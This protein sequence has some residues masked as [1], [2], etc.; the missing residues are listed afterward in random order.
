[1]SA[2]NPRRVPLPI[3]ALVP[4]LL[5]A[6]R[7]HP[8]AV[9]R[10]EPGAGKTTRV[11]PA[12]L[13]LV[14]PRQ[15]VLLLEPRRVVARAAA[16]R[17][18]WER[19][20]QVGEEVGYKVRFEDRTG[21]RTR[22]VVLTEGLL[23]R[24][25]QD[26]PTLD[27][28]GA[29][30]LDEL[31]ERSVHADLALAFLREVQEVRDDLKVV[32]MSAT[33][34][35]G[36]V[37]DFLGGVPVI[38]APGRTFPVT[39]SLL[40]RAD[41]R[42]PAELVV[43][44]V[45]RALRAEHGDEGG[46]VLAFL[47]GAA[48]IHRAQ[49]VLAPDLADRV[50]V[51]P[52]YG[53]LDP[54]A[55]DRAIEPGP[56]RKVVLSTNLAESSLTIEG[57][58]TVVDSGLEKQIRHD[59]SRGIDRL[60]LVRISRQSADQ[61]AGRAG[62]TRP[63]RAFRLWTASQDAAL[64][65]SAVAEVHRIDLA[66]SLLEVLAWSGGDPRQFRWFERPPD[67][68]IERGLRLLRALGAVDRHGFRLTARGEQLRALPLHP[69]LGA[70][71]LAAH[72]RG[73][74]SEGALLCALA[75]EPDGLPRNSL[76]DAVGSSD[77]LV[78]AERL[79]QLR[80][81][82]AI[83]QARDQLVDVARRQLGRP[84]PRPED[85]EE[86]LLR[87]VLAGFPDRVARRRAEGQDRVR[88]VGGRGARLSPDSVVK[89][90]PLLVVVDVDDSGRPADVARG[91]K[92]TESWVRMASAIE[93]DWLE[94]VESRREV[95]W[96]P[97]REAA[98]GAF[99]RAYF[100]LPLEERFDSRPDPAALAACLET[101]ARTDP[102]RALRPEGAAEV[103]LRRIAFLRRAMPE[104]ELPDLS[105]EGLAA[106]LPELCAGRRSF[107]ELR[108]ADQCGAIR[109]LLGW[110]RARDVDRLAPE[111]VE[112]GGERPLKLRYD[113]DGPPVLAVKLQLLFG[114]ERTP[115]VA[116]GRVPVKV[117][118]LAPN[119]RPVQVTQDLA[120]FWAN[121]YPEVRKELRARYPK[122]AWPEDPYAPPPPRP[123][124]RR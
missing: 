37:A 121:T 71:L 114:R 122:H 93:E 13:D 61:R 103:L 24:L 111:R 67:A 99:V 35:A 14:G 68:M 104:L 123:P 94:G 98:E 48:D 28:V 97:E 7:R 40:E 16:R 109:S 69:R 42:S 57:V 15:K 62:R 20:G 58:T 91:T 70:A 73:V 39:T 2:K 124:R 45:K 9:V 43:A 87:V 64:A 26:D 116:D 47:P 84:R 60:E 22:L 119:Q 83:R 82:P 107:A 90:A 12:L 46:D 105:G 118:L 23:T 8:G 65:P 89:A 108:T 19:G 11:P 27:G 17:I 54:A 4:E 3:D 49:S 50:D 96:N 36:P 56:R 101:A 32:A 34:D 77:L 6:L 113:L 106:V 79:A 63:G 10:A 31:H 55:Q 112:L 92:A 72:Q 66:P 5:D 102:W 100:D 38:D 53:A 120:S 78:R 75:S 41:D 25:L 76:R 29:V 18:A 74:L 117:E 44:A 88:M 85:T 51:V 52:L 115:T 33:L 95:R 110:A 81:A 1:M 80:G 59:P 30:V 21:P 86:A